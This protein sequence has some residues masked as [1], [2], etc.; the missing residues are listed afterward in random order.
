MSANQDTF[1]RDLH[2]FAGLNRW[3]VHPR[4]GY[5]I[6]PTYWLDVGLKEKNLQYPF[7]YLVSTFPTFICQ[8]SLKT[9]T[10]SPGR[11]V[12]LRA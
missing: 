6:R 2:D 10:P 4:A 11:G 7:G 5:A 1:N 3:E 8:T 12:A 9:N